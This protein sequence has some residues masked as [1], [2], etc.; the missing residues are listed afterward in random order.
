VL[1]LGEVIGLPLTVTVLL[2]VMAGF[3]V[4]VLVGI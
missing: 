2:D 3:L 1:T 4:T